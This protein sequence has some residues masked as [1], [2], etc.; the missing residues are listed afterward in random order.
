[1]SSTAQLSARER[2]TSLLDDNSFVEVGAFVTKRSTDFNL[3]QK[4]APAD[5]VITGYGVIDGNLVYVYSQDASSLGGSIGEMHAKKIVHIYDLALKVGA[6]VIGLIDSTG[7]RLQEATDA[8]NGFGEIYLKQSMA[9]G[10]IPQITAVFGNSGGGLAVMASLSDFS[11]MEGKSARLFVNSP[12]ALAAN[13]KEKCDT[14]A[15]NFQAKSGAVDYVGASE[16]EVL[17][18]VRELV[19]LLP[20]NNEDDASYNE[21]E[22]DLNR[23]V[24]QLSSELTDTARALRDISDNGYFFEVKADYAKEMVTG[25]IRLNGMTVGAVA[26]RTE[27]VDDSGKVSE[28]FD[29]GLTSAGCEKAGSFVSF[30]D[31]FEIPVLTLTNVNGYKATVEEEKSI[32]RAAAKL[33]YAFSN[34]TVPKV[35]VIIG[36]AFGTAYISMNS[37]HIGADMVYALPGAQIGMMEA[38]LAAQIICEGESAEAVKEKAAEYEKLQSSAEAAARRGYVDS[39]IEP[40]TVRQHVI[41]SFEMLFTKRENRPAKKHGTK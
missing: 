38:G 8:L 37:K 19:T 2:I 31:A 10:V 22:D 29:G 30:C 20:S 24:T 23:L 17:E 6:P 21:C 1:M 25:F 4:E 5:G 18:K 36:K 15:A 27:V 33:T 39:I 28:K 34:A 35:N 14:A 32:A 41:Y 12:N 40:E 11:F 3:Q 16:A 13:Y 7:L 9:S 26:N